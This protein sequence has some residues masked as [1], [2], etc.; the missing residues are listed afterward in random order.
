MESMKVHSESLFDKTLT[1]VPTT[2]PIGLLSEEQAKN[3]HQQT[4][5]R[6][7]ERGGLGIMEMLDNIHRRKLSRQRETQSDVDELNTLIKNYN[8]NEKEQTKKD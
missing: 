8:S 3:N 1:G 4:L 5:E 2:V 6:L 7:N